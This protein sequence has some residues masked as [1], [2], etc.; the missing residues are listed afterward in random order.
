MRRKRWD[1][2]RQDLARLVAKEGVARVAYD[3]HTHR[4]TLYRLINGKTKRPS[5][6][7]RAIIEGKVASATES[8]GNVGAG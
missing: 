4:A 2:T 6:P 3:T 8:E 1:D 5:G 7:L